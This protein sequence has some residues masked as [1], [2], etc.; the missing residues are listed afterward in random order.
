MTKRKKNNLWCYIADGDSQLLPL[1]YWSYCCAL[2]TDNDGIFAVF[3]NVEH[4][5]VPNDCSNPS[6]ID[7]VLGAV[8][9]GFGQG[10]PLRFPYDYHGY[11]RSLDRTSDGGFLLFGDAVNIPA[12][13]GFEIPDK[14]NLLKLSSTGAEQWHYILALGIGIAAKQIAEDKYVFMTN[15]FATFSPGGQIL[16]LYFFTKNKTQ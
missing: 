2:P 14:V 12:C 5:G 9:N 13:T 11:A 1:G 3:G 6:S 7:F 16:T 15:R 8:N 10:Q 4:G